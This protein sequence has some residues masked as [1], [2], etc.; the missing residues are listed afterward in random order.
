MAV[1]GRMPRTTRVSESRSSLA[2][3]SGEIRSRVT[4]VKAGVLGA[5]TNGTRGGAG[6]AERHRSSV[7]RLGRPRLCC[8]RYPPALFLRLLLS[9]NHIRDEATRPDPRRAC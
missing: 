1:S 3:L 5:A 4:N 8:V 9:D 6:V 2:R 7:N